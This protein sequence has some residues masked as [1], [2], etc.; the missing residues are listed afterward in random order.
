MV[1]LPDEYRDFLSVFSEQ[2]VDHFPPSHSWDH[3]INL[4]RDAPDHLNC[5]VYPMNQ[6]EDKALDDFIN[7]QLAK[8]HIRLSISP[9]ASSFFFIKKKDGK[10]H[11]VQDYQGVNKWTV[12]N[13]YPLPLITSLIRNLGGALLYT[14]LDIRWGYNNVHIKEG[15]KWKA[16]FKTQCGLCEPTVMFFSLTNSPATFQAMMNDIYWDTIVK[17]KNC[18]TFIRVYLDNI[19]I[20]TKH[21]SLADHQEAVCNVLTVAKDNSL[22]FKLSKCIFHAS[23]IDYLGIILEKGVMHMDPIKVAGIKNW[24]TPTCIKDVCSFHS[25]CNF[26][27][28][29][30]AGFAS[31]AKCSMN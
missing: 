30:I 29:F 4:K 9:Y 13:Q 19:A 26:Y 21:P 6:V 18:R 7:K 23:L 2:E 14:K 11:P 1:T 8:E 17:H 31:L 25:F 15:D 24:L 20:M 3:A 5:S 22:F 27:Q 10:L 28:P 16:A 12:H